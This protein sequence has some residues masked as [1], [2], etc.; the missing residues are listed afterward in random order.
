MV[1]A[2][3]HETTL[4]RRSGEYEGRKTRVRSAVPGC[5][6]LLLNMGNGEYRMRVLGGRCADLRR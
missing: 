2:A 6:G 4:E 5:D 1:K 3:D